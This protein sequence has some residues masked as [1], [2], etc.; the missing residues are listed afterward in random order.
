M[1]APARSHIRLSRSR[2]L[3]DWLSTRRV[4][5]VL[6]PHI[7]DAIYSLGGWLARSIRPI[8]IHNVF[9]ETRF[10]AGGLRDDAG[11]IR[12]REEDEALATLA[13]LVAIERCYHGL[14]DLSARPSDG[15]ITQLEHDV[16][17]VVLAIM[18]NASDGY[19]VPMGVGAHPDHLLVASAAKKLSA[20]RYCE[21]PY[22]MWEESAVTAATNVLPADIDLHLAAMS[23]FKSQV[24]SSVEWKRPLGSLLS[25]LRGLP[26]MASCCS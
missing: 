11:A 3:E 23:C 18:C 5:H 20:I 4:I 10:T 7:D 2:Q 12:R 1:H 17:E 14:P 16:A 22:M 9:S 8:I 6:S 24:A 15:C 19:L 13:P 26:V 25:R 21:I